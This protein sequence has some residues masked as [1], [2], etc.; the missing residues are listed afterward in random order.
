[1]DMVMIHFNY[2]AKKSDRNERLYV[3]LCWHCHP[4]KVNIHDLL[5]N[6]C[7]S[8]RSHSDAMFRGHEHGTWRET[9]RAVEAWECCPPVRSSLVSWGAE[10][11][12][13]IV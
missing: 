1:M 7:S 8:W 10:G 11:P 13:Y 5:V 6:G 2:R 3:F 4:C 12:L 9:R